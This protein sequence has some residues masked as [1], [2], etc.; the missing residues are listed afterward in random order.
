M[1]GKMLVFG[2]AA[3]ALA[4]SACSGED[5]GSG[6]GSASTKATFSLTDAPSDDLAS[7][8]IELTS[9]SLHEQGGASLPVFPSSVGQTLVVNLLS[10]RGV[11]KLLSSIALPA[12]NYDSLLVSYQSASAVDKSGNVLT[13]TPASGSVTINFVPVLQASGG[14]MHVE[15]DFD[16]AQSVS[17]VTMGPGGS[18]SLNPTI[19]ARL[20]SSGVKHAE[21]FKAT[22][23]SVKPMAMQVTLGGG[24]LAVTVVSTTVVEAGGTSTTGS[25]T[26]FDLNNYVQINDIVELAGNYNAATA[27]LEASRIEVE[28]GLSGFSGPEAEGVVVG[29]AASQVSVLV[30]DA[31]NSGL[32]PGSVQNFSVSASTSYQYDD[33]YAAATFTSIGLGQEVRV[34]GT[35]GSPLVAQQLKLRETSLRGGITAV[36]AGLNQATLNVTSIEGVALA[37]VPGFTNPVT[38]QFSGPIPTA[39]TVGA[40]VEL[41]GHFNRSAAGLF[42]VGAGQTGVENETA[43]IE[44]TVFGVTTSSPI[45]LSITGDGISMGLPNPSTIKVVLTAACVIIERDSGTIT[46]IS[47]S[48]LLAGINSGRYAELRAE[49]LYD[50]ATNTLTA[51]NLRADLP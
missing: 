46:P 47:S 15:I 27:I 50:P 22:V 13:V 21:D 35:T 10:L 5:S 42:D 19:L 11:N 1:N 12:G 40:S 32:S 3:L 43:E 29:L 26:G 44:G 37:S 36:N 38:V 7:L 18:V 6:S 14:A 28:D 23:V 16:V 45:E 24:N 49:G 8:Q 48:A 9:V 17:A 20:E 33:P 34:T 25:A 4:L 2:I 31:R 39:V 41:E 51:S 30:L